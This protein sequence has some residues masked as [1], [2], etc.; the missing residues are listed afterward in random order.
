MQHYDNVV[1]G[2]TM[3][4]IGLAET[5]EENLI[6]VECLAVPGG[7]FISAFEPGYDREAEPGSDAACELLEELRRREIMTD[8]G[9]HLPAIAPVLCNR[10]YERKNQFLFWTEIIDVARRDS[11]QG[12]IVTLANASGISRIT[13]GR[14]IDTNAQGPPVSD[15][16]ADAPEVT[17]RYLNALLHY[18][19]EENPPPAVSETLVPGRFDAE[20]YWRME[21]D[22]DA[23]WP[24][25]RRKL[26]DAWQLHPDRENGWRIASAATL[27]SE[28]VVNNS[29][30]PAQSD[31]L[32]L[33]SV[34]C[35]NP[36]AAF[37]E[38]VNF[39]RSM[40]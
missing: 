10:I 18:T 23:D 4:G 19:G 6:V 8:C 17:K 7:E 3:A 22:L 31:W 5:L 35:G 15:P 9:L 33:P 28:R 30:K 25:A 37:D 16:P 32:H 24:S 27:F 14:I 13:A 20:A 34:A 29:E 12:Y 39:G 21:T 40:I 2:A 26:A 36:I 38:G 11:G 1:L